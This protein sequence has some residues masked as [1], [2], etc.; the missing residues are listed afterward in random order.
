MSYAHP[1]RARVK[2]VVI[3]RVVKHKGKRKLV[4]Q[5]VTIPT[6]GPSIADVGMM[7][8]PPVSTGPQIPSP[9][10]SDLTPP[11]PPVVGQVLSPG[12]V[13]TKVVTGPGGYVTSV[14]NVQ[15]PPG[16][17]WDQQQQTLVYDG[18]QTHG[19][20]VVVD[21]PPP[22]P[23]QVRLPPKLP[24]TLSPRFTPDPGTGAGGITGVRPG[25]TILRRPPTPLGRGNLLQMAG[26]YYRRGDWMS[27]FECLGQ[28]VRQVRKA[29]RK[30]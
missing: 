16:W 5:V 27:C 4:S 25:V 1:H 6:V 8:S 22:P 30:R 28:L 15:A 26:D 24:P 12:N 23:I 20:P 14:T 10:L 17:H 3:H 19:P 11:P 9:V 7:G 2:H 13:V 18:A 29:R 21:H